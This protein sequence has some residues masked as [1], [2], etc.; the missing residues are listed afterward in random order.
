MGDIV[1]ASDPTVK[2]RLAAVKARLSS[3]AS[4]VMTFWKKK[5]PNPTYGGFYGNLNR[6][7]NKSP[8]TDK[9]LVQQTRHLWAFSN[10]YAM[11]EPTPEVKA[12]ADDTYKVSRPTSTTRAPS[13]FRT[14]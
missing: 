4:E 13:N 9:G 5:G 3:L 2:A 12:I 14:R 7:G 10:W 11:K 1:D 8:P 6:M